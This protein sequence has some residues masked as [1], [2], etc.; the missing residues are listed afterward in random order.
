MK[1][2]KMAMAAC[3]A[4]LAGVVYGCIAGF[5]PRGD[6]VI[7]AGMMALCLA[8]CRASMIYRKRRR[9]RQEAEAAA[10]PANRSTARSGVRTL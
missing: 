4:V 8:Y 5:C 7:C 3:G 6:A 10:L 9:Q 1:T 2:C